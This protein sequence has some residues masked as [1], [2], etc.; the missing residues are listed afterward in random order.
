MQGGELEEEFWNLPTS[1]SR[2][3]SARFLPLRLHKARGVECGNWWYGS[4]E[5]KNQ[6]LLSLKL[7]FFWIG[8]NW[9]TNETCRVTCLMLNFTNK[10][11]VHSFT[12]TACSIHVSN[13]QYGSWAS[14]LHHNITDIL[15]FLCFVWFSQLEFN[16]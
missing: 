3:Y 2:P 5:V 14:N 10:I 13:T 1:I 12:F 4:F 15:Y 7:M 16:V 6:R 8:K 11:I 9:N